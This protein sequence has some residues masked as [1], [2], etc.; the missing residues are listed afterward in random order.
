MSVSEPRDSILE[1][2]LP[3]VCPCRVHR[4]SLV[5]RRNWCLRHVQ[6]KYI[7]GFNI[8][9]RWCFVLMIVHFWL[10]SAGWPLSMMSERNRKIMMT[11]SNG[12]IFRVTGLLRGEFT[13][14]RRIPRTK[15]KLWCFLWS[16]SEPTV[17]QTIETPVIWD[18]I[19]LIMTSLK[20][21]SAP[22]TDKTNS[23]ENQWENWNN[24]VRE[25]KLVSIDISCK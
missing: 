6:L 23:P 2:V 25:R 3:H 16:A 24:E 11:S 7:L 5:R 14:Q 1:H 20:C 13:G 15:A 22:Y 17:E 19:A 9:Y 18:A 8:I 21:I 10:V 12:N 4:M